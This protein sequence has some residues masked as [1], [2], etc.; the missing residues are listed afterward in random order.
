MI[1]FF[2]HFLPARTILHPIPF[3][4][5]QFTWSYK[6][7]QYLCPLAKKEN[8]EGN[9]YLHSLICNKMTRCFTLVMVVWTTLI[10]N[11]TIRHQ[12]RI[13]S[14]QFKW[15]SAHNLSIIVCQRSSYLLVRT[16]IGIYHMQAKNRNH[17]NSH[18]Q[19]LPL[20][21]LDSL[22]L[23][24]P[25]QHILLLLSP[26][27]KAYTP[28]SHTTVQNVSLLVAKVTWKLEEKKVYKYEVYKYISWVVFRHNI[29]VA[30]LYRP[31]CYV[32]F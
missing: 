29:S 6:S 8:I 5:I 17:P 23:S 1:C 22:L 19:L 3:Q 9:G 21:H 32:M 13:S 27:H 7:L 31:Y 10:C 4:H 12:I 2:P 11:L 15:T 20:Y 24:S 25:F 16:P 26:P 18:H 28:V 14:F 30:S